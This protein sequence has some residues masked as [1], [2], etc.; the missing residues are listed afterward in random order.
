M[1]CFG[2]GKPHM[3]DT[4]GRW[5][6][7]LGYK[8]VDSYYR[9]DEVRWSKIKFFQSKQEVLDPPAPDPMKECSIERLFEL[10]PKTA[11]EVKKKIDLAGGSTIWQMNVYGPESRQTEYDELTDWYRIVA[12]FDS[13]GTAQELIEWTWFDVHV[14]YPLVKMLCVAYNRSLGRRRSRQL[15]KAHSEEQARADKFWAEEPTIKA[16]DAPKGAPIRNPN[17]LGYPYKTPTVDE[18]T[19]QNTQNTQEILSKLEKG[20]K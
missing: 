10:Y 13:E 6:E 2:R 1:I 12:F 15:S 5:G 7:V 18:M 16:G 19:T 14:V 17:A 11:A 3:R 4:E 20:D 9:T 8:Q